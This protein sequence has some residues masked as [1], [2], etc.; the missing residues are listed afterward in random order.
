MWNSLVPGFWFRKACFFHF[1][2]SGQSYIC[3]ASAQDNI[4]SLRKFSCVW[5]L[6]EITF[7]CTSEEYQ[8]H[9][10]DQTGPFV[11]LQQVFPIKNVISL[12]NCFIAFAAGVIVFMVLYLCDSLREQKARG[13]GL[14][15]FSICP[16]RAALWFPTFG[17]KCRIFTSLPSGFAEHSGCPRAAA[18][19]VCGQHRQRHVPAAARAWDCPCSHR[20][21]ELLSD[22]LIS[23]LLGPLCLHRDGGWEQG[24]S[25]VR[26]VHLKL[27]YEGWF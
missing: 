11:L 19:L 22:L 6:N 24:K 3:S 10:S 7:S 2:S 5:R 25:K 26:N 12:T 14:G 9:L 17:V 8:E 23:G 16:V 15:F 27:E 4:W 21:A 1:I 20:T 18:S 13:M